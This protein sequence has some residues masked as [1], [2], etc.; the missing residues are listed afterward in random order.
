LFL[1]QQA[2]KNEGKLKPT[3]EGNESGMTSLFCG[4]VQQ[5]NPFSF[6]VRF[7]LGSL[8]VWILAGF[9]AHSMTGNMHHP[10][11]SPLSANPAHNGPNNRALPGSDKVKAAVPGKDISD[12]PFSVAERGAPAVF[13]AAALP[14]ISSRIASVSGLYPV[15][16]RAPPVF[17]L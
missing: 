13:S 8:F 2:V 7:F 4:F 14:A 1:Q 15:S 3:Q 5:R 10:Q 6:S 17:I 12:F 16:Q 9:P 11:T